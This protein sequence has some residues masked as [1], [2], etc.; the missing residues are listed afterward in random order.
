M[1][2]LRQRH[3]QWQ[4]ST[5]NLHCRLNQSA[6]PDP[7]LADE[8]ARAF[9]QWDSNLTKSV[10]VCSDSYCKRRQFISTWNELSY[11]LLRLG[12]GRAI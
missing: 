8:Y 1:S 7:G 10:P 9:E 4:P 12:D 3:S 5:A 2:A 11:E 6:K